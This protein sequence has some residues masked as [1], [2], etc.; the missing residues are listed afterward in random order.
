MLAHEFISKNLHYINSANQLQKWGHTKLILKKLTRFLYQYVCYKRAPIVDF[1][2]KKFIKKN[3]LQD[4]GSQLQFLSWASHFDKIFLHN[5]ITN[6][7]CGLVK[8]PTI[9]RLKNKHVI[10]LK[11]AYPRKVFPSSKKC[12]K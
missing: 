6:K 11:V 9:F 7:G 4:W 12:A 10:G 8:W 3:L 1:N 2:V 5:L